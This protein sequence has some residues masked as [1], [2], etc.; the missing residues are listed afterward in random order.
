MRFCNAWYCRNPMTLYL[1]MSPPV[2]I[3]SGLMCCFPSV[4]HWTISHKEI[5]RKKKISTSYG[6]R[7]KVTWPRSN[8][9]SK[10]GQVGSCLQSCFIF[11]LL[12]TSKPVLSYFY[13]SSLI[14]QWP[15]QVIRAAVEKLS[16]N[17][18]AS[19]EI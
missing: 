1:F 9:G 8:K 17:L 14:E 19:H 5:Y 2:L 11:T 12:C 18:T 16:Q 13:S 15:T 3:H 6:S 10:Q 4:R 7:S